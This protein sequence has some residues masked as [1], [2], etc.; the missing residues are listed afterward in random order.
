MFNVEAPIP[1]N[2]SSMVRIDVNVPDVSVAPFIL[3]SY[4]L[5]VVSHLISIRYNWPK[6]TVGEQVKLLLL[7]S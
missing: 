1:R 2:I 5:F 6:F 7:S 4:E 3:I